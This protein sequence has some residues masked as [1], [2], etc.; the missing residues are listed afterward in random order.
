MNDFTHEI[1]LSDLSISSRWVGWQTE[2]RDGKPTKVP[3]APGGG[4]AKADDPTTWGTRESAARR[5]A[6]LPKPYGLG[7]VGL[8]L[9]PMGDGSS[10]GGL[11]LDSCRD[12]A[13]G[14][15]DAWAQEIIAKYFSYTEI[16]PSQTGVKV[17]FL[18]ST[19]DLATMQKVMGSEWGKMFKRS[20]G[21][22]P[23][24]IELHLGNR[25]FAVTDQILEG[26]PAELV[27]VATDILLD[28]IQNAGPAFST[29]G[30]VAAVGDVSRK[31]MDRSRSA[32]ALSKG[33]E[34]RRAGATFE[35][36]V[37][38]LY[39]DPEIAEWARTK[40][41]ANQ[42]REFKRI[43]EK[44]EAKGPVIR[45]VAGK[46]HIATTAAEDALIAS[47]LP[48]YQRGTVGLVHPVTRLVPASRGRM[49]L[50][51]CLDKM[52]VYST[53]DA[54]CGTAEFEKFD[55]RCEDWVRI[56]PP[57]M[58]AQILL[59]RHGEWRFP[60]IAGIITT[61]TLRPDGSVLSA[62]GY[63]AR[64]R[65]H[66]AIDPELQLHQAVDRP[67]R[68]TAVGA[69]KALKDLLQEFV[70]ASEVA[71]SVAL[72]CLITPIV[73]GAMS[74]A[75]LHAIKAH[76]AGSGKSFLIDIASSIASGRPC[77]VTSAAQDENETEKRIAG[78]LLAAYPIVSIDNCNGELGGDLLCQ[79]V[80]RPLIRVRGLGK[81]DIIEIES[82][83]TMFA[84]GNNLR[85]RGDMVR[86]TLIAELDPQVERPETREFKHDPVATILAD[87]GRYV[88]ACLIIVRAYILAGSPDRL[89][90]IAS[91]EDWSNL[92]RSA[93]VWLGCEDPA[94]SM[95]TARGDDPE[96]NELR[97]V[98]NVWNKTFGSTPTTCKQ[99]AAAALEKQTVY[100]V[101][102]DPDFH[103]AR[104]NPLHP[105]LEQILL[106]IAGVRGV[107]D[108]NKLGRWMLNKEGRIVGKNRFKRDGLTN[109]SARW[110]LHAT[111]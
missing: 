86:R 7:G 77:P 61:P 73:R 66:H 85:V 36:M 40:G 65:L 47:R 57:S 46:L 32:I 25:Y 4:R 33:R 107:I 52:N 95:E 14:L 80:E 29:S 34:L 2:D 54:L 13:S 68:E 93:L 39:A 79:A 58:I 106:Q 11:D 82:S 71:K 100:D 27:H 10:I 15:I 44:A 94:K 109:G 55:A 17:F 41:E 62:P 5:A 102:G 91:F 16:S 48:I 19:A 8:E 69:L 50:A 81:S 78:L 31:S 98:M 18:Y 105:E 87:R 60:V 97:E 1:K 103:A 110:A 42:Q 43:W 75:P 45:V 53:V 89:P 101:H 84:T 26:C 56:N 21:D 6:K 35:E 3:Y 30:K 37:A 38:G 111:K 70:F 64:T 20:G 72:S 67:T 63:D 88:S 108:T 12:P 83:V 92:V 90:P 76:T 22:H 104:R 23:P 99:A 96:L 24:A 74:V 9:G 59:S 51:A 49:T 28:L